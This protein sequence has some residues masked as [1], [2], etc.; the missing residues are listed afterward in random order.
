MQKVFI[1]IYAVPN[2]SYQLGSKFRLRNVDLD[3]LERSPWF[4]QNS[5][6]YSLLAK[7]T[8]PLEF[9]AWQAKP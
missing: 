2:S 7:P 6:T 4:R 5:G 3:P 8:L 1:Y 9:C